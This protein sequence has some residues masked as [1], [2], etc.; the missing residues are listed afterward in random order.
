MQRFSDFVSML[1]RRSPGR[2]FERPRKRC[3]PLCG[4]STESSTSALPGPVRAG[5]GPFRERSG[6]SASAER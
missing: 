6:G 4:S 2:V 1:Y 3:S 5:A